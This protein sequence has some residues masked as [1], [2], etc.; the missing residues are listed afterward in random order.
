MNYSHELKYHIY[1]V[2]MQFGEQ[3]VNIEIESKMILIQRNGEWDFYEIKKHSGIS[4]L[5]KK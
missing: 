3:N 5:K 2:T 4:T 1:Q